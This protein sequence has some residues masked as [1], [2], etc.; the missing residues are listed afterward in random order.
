MAVFALLHNVTALPAQSKRYGLGPPR[1]PNNTSLPMLKMKRSSIISSVMQPNC[2]YSDS[3]E[4]HFKSKALGSDMSTICL[5]IKE[6]AELGLFEDA[7]GIYIEMLSLGSHVYE[8][9]C[10]PSLIKAFSELR[11]LGKAKQVHEHVLKVGITEDVYVGNYLLTMYWKCG[12]VN[13][14]MDLFDRMPIRD[15][16]SWNLV[17]SGFSRFMQPLS[18]LETFSK[19]RDLGMMVDR[20]TS[21]SALS[22]CASCECLTFGRGIHAIVMK[23]G[24]DSDVS[25]S[26]GIVNMY[27][28]CGDCPDAE[29]AFTQARIGNNTIAC[30]AMI[31]GYVYNKCPVEALTFF[32]K[33]LLLGVESDSSTTVSTL[34]SCS[35]LA[36]IDIGR[37]VHGYLITNG[38]L[39]DAR[40]ETTLLDMYCKCG[41][42]EAGL[43]LFK[44][45]QS[46]NNVTWGAIITGCAQ[47]SH[48]AEALELFTQ[49]ISQ[50]GR[51]DSDILLS[52]LRALSSI[53]LKPQGIE[54]H[55]YSIRMGFVCDVFVGGALADMYSKCGDIGSAQKVLLRL[56]KRDVVAWNAL[57]SGYIQNGYVDDALKAF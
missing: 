53:T 18:A 21:V 42:I 55:S 19:M 37:Q 50:G 13:D 2:K 24:L 36:D 44:Q 3:E 10:F 40:V 17:V 49:F 38:L 5:A 4:T 15:T 14:G 23:I 11:D 6:C 28:K 30:T 51:V 39:D 12:S 26:I 35:H 45:L 27:M 43:R 31:S 29:L 16:V 47:N 32:R 20:I 7:I 33:M 25:V 56:P 54:V 22:A 48:P 52:V 46:C 8:F 1:F 57:I 34:V 9:P 41:N